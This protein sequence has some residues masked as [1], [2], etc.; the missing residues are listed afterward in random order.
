MT[1]A[2][3]GSATAGYPVTA[4]ECARVNAVILSMQIQKA[5]TWF[6]NKKQNDPQFAAYWIGLPQATKDA[7]YGQWCILG[8]QTMEKNYIENIKDGTFEPRL[9][10][11]TNGGW[12][13]FYNSKAI[14]TALGNSSYGFDTTDPNLQS[15][16]YGGTTPTPPPRVPP[17]TYNNDGTVT[18]NKGGTLWAICEAEKNN[19]NNFISKDDLRLVNENIT[20]VADTDIPIGTILVIPKRQGDNLVASSEG[21]TMILNTKTGQCT[22]QGD[23]LD[24]STCQMFE[25]ICNGNGRYTDRY[26]ETDKQTGQI[27]Q[28]SE[29]TAP[30]TWGYQ[31]QDSGP[32][33]NLFSLTNTTDFNLTGSDAL[34]FEALAAQV[35]MNILLANGVSFITSGVGNDVNTDSWNQSIANNFISDYL[36]PADHTI[37]YA[38]PFTRYNFLGPAGGGDIFTVDPTLLN[39]NTQGLIH[40]VPTDPLVL[41]L[42]GDG[43]KLTD[44]S[45]NPVLFDAD[46][47]GKSCSSFLFPVFMCHTLE[48]GDPLV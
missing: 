37:N 20:H 48:S 32:T 16:A 31:F 47:D 1:I 23:S 28:Q 45:S 26:T 17:I 36:R 14:G 18:I 42:N 7:L 19:S 8:P 33:T 41:D 29:E 12:D 3:P 44:F 6:E 39:M 10:E 38:G 4:E 21:C 30:F 9:G 22:V 27:L 43:V 5:L 24:G 13:I 15:A 40:A 2:G 11:K 34:S 25:R 46:H 35:R